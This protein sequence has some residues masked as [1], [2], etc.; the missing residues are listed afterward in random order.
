MEWN[1]KKDYLY[2]V[3][4][5]FSC[6]WVKKKSFITIF[7]GIRPRSHNSFMW[8]WIDCM[9]E[10]GYDICEWIDC[11]WEQG[12]DMSEWIDF[13]WEQGYCKWEWIIENKA[14]VCENEFISWEDFIRDI[15]SFVIDD[16]ALHKEAVLTLRRHID[17]Q[18]RW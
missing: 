12:Y 5:I 10:Q 16:W 8:E 17:Y 13:K 15:Q 7:L 2:L 3:I 14:M 6:V 11:M 4:S 9:W 18:W 1:T